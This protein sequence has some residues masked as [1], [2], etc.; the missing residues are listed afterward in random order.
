MSLM[1]HIIVNGYLVNCLYGTDVIPIFISN[2][3]VTCLVEYH[4]DGTVIPKELG[5][6]HVCGNS[7]LQRWM[8]GWLQTGILAVM[9]WQSRLNRWWWVI[10]LRSMRGYFKPDPGIQ[11][12]SS[13]VKGS[14]SSCRLVGVQEPSQPSCLSWTRRKSWSNCP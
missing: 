6:E 4:N 8:R 2:N 13:S 11:F 7:S 10:S 14:S 1:Y 3:I 5:K 9:N 12:R